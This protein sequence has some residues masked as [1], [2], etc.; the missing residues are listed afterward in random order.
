M[1]S[2]QQVTPS[3][4][5]MWSIV[6]L[7]TILIIA[8]NL[9]NL[10]VVCT[11]LSGLQM[12]QGSV[13]YHLWRKR[14]ESLWY[15]H[16]ANTQTFLLS[17]RVIWNCLRCLVFVFSGIWI[18]ADVEGGVHL[19]SAPPIHQCCTVSLLS[20]S[21]IHTN[22]THAHHLQILTYKQT[23]THLFLTSDT[24]CVNQI[25]VTMYDIVQGGAPMLQYHPIVA[26]FLPLFLLLFSVHLC[27]CVSVCV[28]VWESVG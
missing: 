23:N 20:R 21:L 24:D 13:T 18:T 9:V 5:V 2:L 27:V 7:K 12:S 28:C 8:G 16:Q 11:I 25:C 14:A 17:P 1:G 3:H 10:V 6:N 19:T 26:V 4:E 22:L 15:N